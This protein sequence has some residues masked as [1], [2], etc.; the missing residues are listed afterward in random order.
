MGKKKPSTKGD[1]MRTWRDIGT[2]NARAANEEF[3]HQSQQKASQNQ[4][5][6]L[7]DIVEELKEIKGLLKQIS[8]QVSKL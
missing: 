3:R 5:D 7:S 4:S 2:E 6:L 1:F 8:S